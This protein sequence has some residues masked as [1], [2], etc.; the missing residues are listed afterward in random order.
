[1][2]KKTQGLGMPF[3]CGTARVY[4]DEEGC[5]NGDGSIW[6]HPAH[7]TLPTEKEAL[8][9]LIGALRWAREGGEGKKADVHEVLVCESCP[10]LT[11]HSMTCHHPS[12]GP[13]QDPVVEGGQPPDW[14]LLRKCEA[15]V[16]LGAERS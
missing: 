7:G 12:L 6:W 15:W 2:T 9:R 3:S 11:W 13:E 14:C 8:S 1:M 10:F 16:V 5:V 4:T